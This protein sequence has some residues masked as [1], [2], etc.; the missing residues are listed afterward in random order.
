[1]VYLDGIGQSTFEYLP[2]IQEFLGSLAPVLPEDVLL[3]KGIMLYSVRNNPLTGNRPWH[4]SGA[5]L[6]IPKILLACLVT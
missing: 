6:T 4:S 1:M 3:I 2:D 5:W